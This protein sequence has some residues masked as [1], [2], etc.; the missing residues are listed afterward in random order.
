MQ[1]NIPL[2]IVKFPQELVPSL[3][4]GSN[5]AF[6]MVTIIF[7]KL[8]IE[9]LERLWGAINHTWSILTKAL[10]LDFYRREFQESS[11]W[12]FFPQDSKVQTIPLFPYFNQ[13]LVKS[14]STRFPFGPEYSMNSIDSLNLKSFIGAQ[15][16]SSEALDDLLAGID[17]KI[18][19]A[20][21]KYL[22][23]QRQASAEIS[24]IDFL[25]NPPLHWLTIAKAYRHVETTVTLLLLAFFV[26][27]DDASFTQS[28]FMILDKRLTRGLTGSGLVK[29][30]KHTSHKKI[31]LSRLIDCALG[32]SALFLKCNP[33]EQI[34]FQQNAQELLYR[35]TDNDCKILLITQR[36]VL[37]SAIKCRCFPIIDNLGPNALEHAIEE[38]P[39]DEDMLLILLERFGT[40]QLAKIL[41]AI[42]TESF[43][44]IVN[45][46]PKFME[47]ILST[48]A[49]DKL[50]EMVKPLTA[51]EFFYLLNNQQFLKF[52][53]QLNRFPIAEKT[54]EIESLDF[55]ILSHSKPSLRMT[56]DARTLLLRF[57]TLKPYS[58]FPDKI[59]QSQAAVYLF[60]QD[61]F[62]FIK[63]TPLLADSWNALLKSTLLDKFTAQQFLALALINIA[64]VPCIVE[65]GYLESKFT[66]LKDF[67][68][69][70]LRYLPYI[71]GTVKQ[72]VLDII[73]DCYGS[74][75]LYEQ[76]KGK[77][78]YWYILFS[79]V[80]PNELTDERLEQLRGG[81]QDIHVALLNKITEIQNKQ[82]EAKRVEN[83]KP[84]NPIVVSDEKASS[85]LTNVPRLVRGIHKDMSQEDE[86]LDIDQED[87]TW[88]VGEKNEASS[89]IQRDK[90]RY[91]NYEEG[92]IEPL[93]KRVPTIEATHFT[94]LSWSSWL[95]GGLLILAGVGVLL[96]ILALAEVPFSVATCK[97]IVNALVS[98]TP[99]AAAWTIF[100]AS[101]ILGFVTG[102]AS[103]IQD[104]LCSATVRHAFSSDNANDA[105]D[106]EEPWND[107]HSNRCIQDLSYHNNNLPTAT[108]PKQTNKID[109]NVLDN[110]KNQGS[111]TVK[112]TLT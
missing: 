5:L 110:A 90:G 82:D 86:A 15:C 71:T 84:N 4:P 30:S 6:E 10:C 70:V 91:L 2:E 25:K 58:Y 61:I 64:V 17:R 23:K 66:D 50:C 108:L 42:K 105:L 94:R 62:T 87:K 88:N 79:A 36:S 111:L 52:L 57:A 13:F 77:N 98:C 40:A 69:F 41:P 75:K 38:N 45:S 32:E 102:V 19:L 24:F 99:E 81:C 20:E 34:I 78:S 60:P 12:A 89:V 3:F 43:Q 1:Q 18:L 16:M 11:L 37:V 100:T 7:S 109:S 106:N 104:C 47:E 112:S 56:C 92:E 59:I 27:H 22:I 80:F 55:G 29:L 63:I 8:P 54:V 48:L 67:A 28:I 83:L 103:L 46:C 21:E 97:A 65:K 53:K 68:E 44:I 35:L 26:D 73:T 76:P 9:E 14:S 49:I 51:E 93:L 72:A 74:W 85:T 107:V 95:K 101:L 96:S 31:F 33:K 39:T